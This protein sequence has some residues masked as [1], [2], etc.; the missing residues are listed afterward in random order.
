MLFKH[1]ELLYGLF[2]LVIPVLV[3]LFQLRRFKQER[4]TNV[5]FLKKAE[6]QTR[7]SSTVKKWLILLSRL[8]FLTAIVIA[9]AQP[10]FPSETGANK[11]DVVIYL[12]NSFSMQAPGSQGELLR[13]S[14][15]QLLEIL[16]QDQDITLFTNNTAYRN[17][18]INSLKREL[19]QLN[20]SFNQ[21]EWNTILG[22]AGP[23]F[24]DAKGVLK[25]LILIS[26]FQNHE[27]L[28]DL[29]L[30]KNIRISLVQVEPILKQ[31]SS[32]D[33]A[34]IST[35]TLDETILSVGINHTG[36]VSHDIP[37]AIYNG[38]DLLGK[39]TL[40]LNDENSTTFD[41]PLPDIPIEKGRIEI[42]DKGLEFD[43]TLYFSL[44]KR[45]PLNVV[46]IGDADASFLKGIYK[47]PDFD[48]KIFPPEK[49]VYSDLSSANLIVLNEPERISSSLNRT[50]ID[51]VEN[52]VY[53]VII[54]SEQ[55]D[56]EDY[57][58]LLKNL[59][60]PVFEKK[61]AEE[62]LI[63][64]II[65]EHPL[66]S[67]VF[68]EQ[69]QN[70]QYPSLDS[71]FK[72]SGGGE[73]ILGLANKE[74]FLLMRGNVFLFSG[75]LNQN[76]SNFQSSPLI[77]PTFYNIGN[78]ALTPIPLYSILGR[79]QKVDVTV[80]LDKDEILHLNSAED[81]FIPLQQSFPNKVVMN[82]SDDFGRPG[83]YEVTRDSTSL[84]SLSFN[85][86]REE[87]KLVYADLENSESIVIEDSTASVI[88][89]LQRETEINALWKW[90]VIFAL[91]FILLEMLILKFLK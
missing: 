85:I 89:K 30:P 80:N 82:L 56:L 21:L 88:Q 26:D 8:L 90:F 5:A 15:Q 9:F 1:P 76:N 41:F 61:I 69:V 71:Y 59:K 19:Q 60:L 83:H 48:L 63:T 17:L 79:D 27:A 86:T 44:N 16:P 22:K 65:Y 46:V 50:L 51:L 31:N 91:F 84:I 24:S 64:E 2:L 74:D 81:S 54:P 32:I 37:V 28:I 33:T 52:N 6:L 67:M 10:Y 49:L 43:N 87:S 20:F 72:L 47:K 13:S 7:K 18:E 23:Y 4:F 40:N 25:N 53:M 29:E 45:E 12:D 58:S 57:N 34:Y 68:E 78:L 66:F 36:N 70:F 42:E 55:A 14:V 75:A 11:Q 62:K 3:H 38:P 73:K 39:R 35:Q 77:V